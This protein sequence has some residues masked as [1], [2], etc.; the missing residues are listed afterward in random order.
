MGYLQLHGEIAVAGTDGYNWQGVSC[1]YRHARIAA[2]ETVLDMGS[3]LGIDSFIAATATSGSGR[4]VGVD[5]AAAEVRHANARAAARGLAERAIFEVADFERL[6]MDGEQFDVIISNGAFCL[7]PDK[8][9]AFR[10]AYRVLKPG[11]RVTICLSVLRNP[12]LPEGAHWP[13]CMQMFMPLDELKPVVE[14]SGL[15]DVRIDT[16]DSLMAFEIDGSSPEVADTANNAQRNR[17]HV[18]SEE[19]EHLKNFD[20]NELCARVVVTGRK[21]V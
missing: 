5:I 10:E 17:V 1:P 13:L 11:G 14:A 18:G 20:M 16:S 15:T 4:V 21:V 3:G 6:P 8:A 7:A 12:K 19:F 2:G 9:A